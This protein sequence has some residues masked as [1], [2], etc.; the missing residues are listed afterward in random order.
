MLNPMKGVQRKIRKRTIFSTQTFVCSPKTQFIVLELYEYAMKCGKGP[1][2]I[3]HHWYS[4]SEC[5]ILK[6]KVLIIARG[7]LLT[8]ALM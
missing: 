5:A 4:E 6:K 7:Y 8:E 2:R 3:L 1:Q